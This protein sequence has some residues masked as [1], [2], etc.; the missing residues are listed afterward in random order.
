LSTRPRVAGRGMHVEAPYLIDELVNSRRNSDRSRDFYEHV[1]VKIVAILE[2]CIRSFVIELVDGDG[3]Y[4]ERADKIVGGMKVNFSA[5]RAFSGKEVSAGDF[6]FHFFS[7]VSL[8]A[9]ISVLSVLVDGFDRRLAS[10]HPL[11]VKDHDTWPQDP[12]IK[13]YK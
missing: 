9:I 13:N 6:V 8:T 7:A 12:V 2:N 10:V 4:M 1:G 11:L 3:V 5:A